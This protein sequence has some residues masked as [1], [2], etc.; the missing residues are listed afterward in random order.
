MKQSKT[1]QKQP[2]CDDFDNKG[3]QNTIFTSQ[4]LFHSWCQYSCV[5]ERGKKSWKYNNESDVRIE[6]EF[7]YRAFRFS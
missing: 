7:F 5:Q 2:I 4:T 6:I 1:K 3:Y